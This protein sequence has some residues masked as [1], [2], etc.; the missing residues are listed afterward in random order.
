MAELAFPKSTC[1]FWA[2]PKRKRSAT[3]GADNIESTLSTA[4]FAETGKFHALRRRRRVEALADV[5]GPTVRGVYELYGT[6]FAPTG[7]L[8]S[9]AFSVIT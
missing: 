5:G 4:E 9:V 7:T 8:L 6:S 2:S 3:S 1:Y